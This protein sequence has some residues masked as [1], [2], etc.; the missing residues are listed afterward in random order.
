MGSQVI[1]MANVIVTVLV[2]GVVSI[3]ATWARAVLLERT[4]MAAADVDAGATLRGTCYSGHRLMKALQLAG[5]I[6]VPCMH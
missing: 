1:K 3:K 4:P 6:A 5:N 2:V